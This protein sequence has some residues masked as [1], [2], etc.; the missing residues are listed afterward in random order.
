[1]RGQY[2]ETLSINGKS[3]HLL[4]ARLVA[5]PVEL[6]N[7]AEAKSVPVPLPVPGGII[8]IVGIPHTKNHWYLRRAGVV[9]EVKRGRFEE[10]VAE[11]LKDVPALADKV[12]RGEKAYHYQ[13]MPKIVTE[14]NQQSGAAGGSN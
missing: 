2:S 9:T 3:L 6:F 5:G 8:P 1:M 12:R 4:A 13:D 10:Q 7:F 11:Y 14:Y